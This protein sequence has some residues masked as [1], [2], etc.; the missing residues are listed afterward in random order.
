MSTLKTNA[1]QIGQSVTATNN[2]TLYQPTTPDGTVRLGVGNAG[3]T[4]DMLVAKSDGSVRTIPQTSGYVGSNY[5]VREIEQFQMGAGGIT[6]E[7]MLLFPATSN[8][9]A[10]EARQIMGKIYSSR[11]SSNT[12][13][14]F[15]V[16]EINVGR[17]YTSMYG[18][19]TTAAGSSISSFIG[20]YFVTYAGVQYMAAKARM[21]GGNPHNGIWFEGWI[22]GEDTNTFKR[23]RAADISGITKWRDGGAEPLI[24]TGVVAGV[25]NNFT[26]PV[27]PSYMTTVVYV[28]GKHD[29]QG[30]NGYVSMQNLGSLVTTENNTMTIR[31]GSIEYPATGNL[32]YCKLNGGAQT[33]DAGLDWAG[34]FTINQQMSA[35]P[36]IMIDFHYT[37]NNVGSAR[38]TGD[39][40]YAGVLSGGITGLNFDW[41]GSTVTP[42]LWA[43]WISVSYRN[44]F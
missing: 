6:D 36:S 27:D 21:D 25:S 4:S 41:D 28:R 9:S 26:V 12:G 1:A 19:I 16:D 11:G 31:R 30:A 42:N 43:N 29:Q 40:Q 7:Y 32:N 17:A 10:Q 5:V 39:M 33:I 13:N 24:Q 14:S 3:S 35:R 15:A 23:V 20:L 22:I 37:Y 44:A 34:T 18:N 2:F 8:Y 38:T